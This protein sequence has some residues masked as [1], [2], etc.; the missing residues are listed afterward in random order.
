MSEQFEQLN[1][2]AIADTG[3]SPE[4]AARQKKLSD[5]Q[6]V[7]ESFKQ[8]SSAQTVAPFLTSRF[9]IADQR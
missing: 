3:F 1:Q 4:T 6:P 7:F 9:T 2:A 5:L 8:W